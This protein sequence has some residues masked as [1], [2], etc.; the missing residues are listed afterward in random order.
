MRRRL[1]KTFVPARLGKC[2]RR[3]CRL[4]NPKV[5]LMNK[6]VSIVFAAG[7]ALLTTGAQVMPL[8]AID[9][10]SDHP[11]RAR[12]RPGWTSRPLRS[13][14]AALRLS[15][16]LAHRP[17]AS[18]ASAIAGIDWMGYIPC[19][20]FTRTGWFAQRCCFTPVLHGAGS[21]RSRSIGCWRPRAQVAG[22][23][24]APKR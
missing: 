13:P 20:N 3:W 24:R 10:S 12:L 2:F 6:L 14:P 4:R 9:A 15:A 21:R 11:G 5:T 22:E 17:T 23:L 19:V 8:P 16:R 7:L 1:G 18:T